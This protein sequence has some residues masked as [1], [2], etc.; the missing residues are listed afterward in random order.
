MPVGANSKAQLDTSTR[1]WPLATL[2]LDEVRAYEPSELVL[3]AGAGAKL[4][5]LAAM[6]AS[7]GQMLGFEA[8]NAEDAT[9]GGA[10]ASGIAGP[11]RPFRGAIRDF[12]LGVQVLNGRAERLAFGGQ[13]IKN[14]AGYDASRLFAAS[15]GTLG[16]LLEV[17]LRVLPRPE[18]EVGIALDCGADAALQRMCALARSA[19]PLSG[20]AYVDGVLHVRLAGAAS[21]VEA[22]KQRIGAGEMHAWQEFWTSLADA[23]HA[24]FC[25]ETP[26]YRL[27]VPPAMPHLPVPGRWLIDWG[28]ALRWLATDV[29]A[30]EWLASVEAAGGQVLPWPPKRA[31]WLRSGDAAIDGL[32]ARIREAFDPHGVFA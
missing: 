16:V 4:K 29:P 28:G 10:V 26:V 11:G 14:V 23:R 30:S 3:T 12:V 27:S 6:L 18:T 20:A 24:F 15:W 31:A 25:S 2:D 19:C 13:V 5:D 9:L 22:A 7:E 17:S 32:Q 8:F 21:S 1:C